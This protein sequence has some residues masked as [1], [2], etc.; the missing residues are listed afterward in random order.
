MQPYLGTCYTT[1][2][3]LYHTLTANYY[4]IIVPEIVY[5]NFNYDKIV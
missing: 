5:N 2:I 3:L 4:Y 1:S